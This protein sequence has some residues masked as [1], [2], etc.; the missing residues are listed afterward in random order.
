[1]GEDR[2]ENMKTLAG[3]AEAVLREMIHAG[4]IGPGERVLPE[5]VARRLGMS[6]IPVR[7]ALRSLS[8]RGLVEATARRGF[9]VRSADA[10][11][12]RETYALR[13]LL[14]PYAV[15]LAVPRL[16]DAAL[17]EMDDRLGALEKTIATNDMTSYYRNHRAFHF[18]IYDQCGSRWLL[19]FI[20]MLW[21]NSH[22]YQRLSLPT[23]GSERKRIAE[24][25]AIAKACRAR[26]AAAARRLVHDHLDHTRRVV[27]R[28]FET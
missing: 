25:R 9:R 20:D 15:E 26:D 14:D 12:F 28:R 5:D 24:H 19:E 8:S 6:A 1:M 2:R 4:E 21:E 17:L 27:T 7:E 13:L 11:D 23:R 22:R 16:D 18:A 3:H 10:D